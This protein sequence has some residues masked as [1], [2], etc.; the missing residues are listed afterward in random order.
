MEIFH[1]EDQKKSVQ[2]VTVTAGP[3]TGGEEG[4]GGVSCEVSQEE[5]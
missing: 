1:Y 2:L 4:R 3:K 5:L